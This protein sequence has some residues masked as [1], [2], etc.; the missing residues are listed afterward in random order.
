[1]TKSDCFFLGY[2]SGSYGFKG[3]V[4]ITLDVDKPGDFKNIESVLI[5]INAELIPYF[6]EKISI[7]DQKAHVKFEGIDS[8]DQAVFIS[9]KSVY[10][11]LSIL[12]QLSGPHFY[13]HEIIGF[14]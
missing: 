14:K 4:S 5:E 2:V 1:M 10:L 13:Y 11:P 7:R 12:P 9:G 6:I 8:D 3:D